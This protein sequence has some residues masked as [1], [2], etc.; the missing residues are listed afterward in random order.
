MHLAFLS[1]LLAL[2]LK[3]LLGKRGAILAGAVFIAAYVF[4][5]G[6]QP[7]L[8]RSAIMYMIGA[9]VLLV[10]LPRQPVVALS[11]SLCLQ[12][13]YDLPQAAGPSFI[14]SY[15]ALAGIL[16]LSD[17]FYQLLEGRLPEALARPLAASLGAFTASSPAV[18]AFFG[19]LRPVGIPAGLL[20]VPLVSLFI[21]LSALYVIGGYIYPLSEVFN[22]LLTAIQELIRRVVSTASLAPGITGSFLPVL[23]LCF[24]LSAAVLAGGNR[25][26]GYRSYLAPFA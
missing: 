3:P 18:I 23:L 19:I 25:R 16:L 22:V 1:G 8:V 21:F 13:L 10:G 7:S 4:L 6:P 12:I 14:L 26:R 17:S 2:L 5:V 24:F 9:A 11:L 20:V 15:T